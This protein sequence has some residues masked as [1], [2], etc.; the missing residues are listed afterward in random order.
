VAGGAGGSATFSVAV[1]NPLPAGVTQVSNT[2]SISDDGT[3]GTDPTPGNN[4]G[5][6]TTPVTANPDL[7]VTKSDG[8]ASVAP[9]G[10]VS[11]TLSY[12]NTGAIGATGVALTETVP[13]NTTFN[14]GASTAGWS[15]TPNNNAGST[16]TLAVGSL[17]AGGTGSATFAVTLINPLPAGITQ[18]SNTA[19]V[20]DDGTNGTDPTPANNSGSDTTPVT[21]APDLSVTKSDGG[22]SV[23][24]GGTVSYTLSYSNAGNRGASGVVLTETVPAD[25]TFNAGASTAGWVCA[26]NNNAGSGCTL[27]IGTVAAGAGGAAT[28]AVTVANP[29]AAGVAQI[30]NTA[31]VADDGTNGTDPTPGNNTGSDTTPVTAQPDL[32]ITKTDGG[33]TATPGGTIA[34]TLNYSNSGNQGAAGVTLTET[35]PANTTFN[36]ASST[37]GW[38]CANGSA[39]GTTCTFS[40]GSLAGGASGSATFAVTVVNPVAAGVTQTSNTASIADDGANGTDPTPANNTGSDTTPVTAAPDLAVTKSDG[41]SSTTAGG[42]V[43]YTV[44]YTNNGDQDAVGVVLNETVPTNTTFNAGSS[45]AGWSCANGS[46]AGTACVFTVGALAAGTNGTATFAVAVNNPLAGGV[47]QISNSVTIADDG[48]NGADPTPANNTGSDTTPV[49]VDSADLSVVKTLTTSGPFTVGQ[50]V[51]FSLLVANAGPSTATNVQVTDTPSNLTITSVTGGGCSA[52]PCT[53]PSLASGSS[54]TITVTATINAIGAFDNSTT[55]TATEGDPDNTNNTDNTGNG[56]TADAL[57][58]DLSITKTISATTL[59]VGQQFHYTIVV[60]NLGPGGA[61]NVVVTD[62]LPATFALASAT[63]TQGS[64]SGTTTVSC[65]IGAM[66]NAATATITI[67]GSPTAAGT[68]SNTA[69]VAAT[70]VESTMANNAST[71]SAAAQPAEVIPTLGEWGLIL[72]GALLALCGL[73][74]IK[75]RG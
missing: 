62:N 67:T 10:T 36:A 26:P 51:T 45:T 28:F 19:S 16:C 7:S 31:S 39:A 30:S 59:Y 54:V 72:L 40:V 11:Y 13:A 66:A 35:V 57:G 25:T 3:N 23:S 38:S 17:A 69:S 5:S 34:Y 61:T 18:V 70:E 6:D 14:A 68:L 4:S 32:S 42:T 49:T 46:P 8:G 48:A 50:S 73:V 60:T 29:V 44:A 21:G 65:N 74:A 41:G 71:A 75:P 20:A 52:L 12:G 47:T 53:I 27:A 24:P 56:G 58:V 33:A 9:G 15:C 43:A 1:N 63:S 22:A 2:A 55:V 64:C 37:A